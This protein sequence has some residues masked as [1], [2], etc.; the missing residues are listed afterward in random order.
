M[1]RLVVDTLYDEIKS[2]NKFKVGY[3]NVI[4]ALVKLP[5]FPAFS[6]IVENE[7]RKRSELSSCQFDNELTIIVLVYQ[8]NKDN[9]FSDRISDLVEEVEKV[10]NSS[11]L[12]SQVID[13]YVRKVTYDGGI[14]HPKYLA[15]LEVKVF[16]RENLS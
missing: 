15:E 16:Y 2:T 3:K 8:K 1:R 4:P 6:I 14:L 11:S 9:D 7:T 5:R 13:M 12:H 10:V